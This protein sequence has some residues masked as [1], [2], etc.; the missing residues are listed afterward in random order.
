M[1]LSKTRII[2]INEFITHSVAEQKVQELFALANICYAP[3]FLFLGSPGG[4]VEASYLI[5]DAIHFIKP[6]VYTIGSGTIA[7]AVALIYFAAN[8]DNRYTFSGTRF[9]LDQPSADYEGSPADLKKYYNGILNMRERL[10]NIFAEATGQPIE[11]VRDFTEHDFWLT[12]LQA[13]DYGL[14]KKIISTQED[15][16]TI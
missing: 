16:P 9:L 5:H 11:K 13:V 15:L 6:T 12:S 8:K 4:D 7:G 3:I 2:L 10:N 14:V 1:Y